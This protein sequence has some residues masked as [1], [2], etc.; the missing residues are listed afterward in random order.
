MFDIFVAPLKC[1]NCGTLMHDAEIKTHIRNVSADSSRFGVGFEFDAL[2]LTIE[3]I[4]D[5][6][7]SLVKPPY[8]DGPIRLLDVWICTQCDTEQWAIV[9]VVDRRISSIKA[10]RLDRV[11]LESVNFIS[12][13][14]VQLLAE[15]LRG[16]QTNTDVSS[17]EILRQRLP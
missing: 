9:E 10:V 16:E 6:D 2:D 5:S 1:P 14:N 13:V 12:E 15:A 17:V 3:S 7:Y 11:T 8:A 4:M